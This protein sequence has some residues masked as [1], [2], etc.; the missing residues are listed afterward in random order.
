MVYSNLSISHSKRDE[1]GDL[2]VALDYIK[3]ARDIDRSEKN[4]RGLIKDYRI[5]AEVYRK[6]NDEVNALKSDEMVR[7]E[8]ADSKLLPVNLLGIRAIM[9][10][11][12]IR[13]A[14]E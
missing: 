9:T 6:M 8:I 4:T 11:W 3:K 12:S 1:P 7:N 10:L 14:A 5:M 13:T 2:D